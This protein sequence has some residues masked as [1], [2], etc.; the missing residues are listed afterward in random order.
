MLR[1]EVMKEKITLTQYHDWWFDNALEF[2]GSL[3]EELKITVD[4]DE[5]IAFN[6]L[7]AEQIEQ[8]VDKIEGRIKSKLTYPRINDAGVTEIK[9]RPYLPTMHKGKYVNFLGKDK[10]IKQEICDYLFSS[11]N[12]EGNKICDVCSSAYEDRYDISQ[13]S[14]IIYPAVTGSLKSQCGIRKME[15]EYHACP[16]CA[17]LGSIEWL[18]DNPF[19]CDNENLTNYILFPKIVDISDLHK[20][21]S[22][23]RGS[24]T[25]GNLTN[26]IHGYYTSK[27]GMQY[28]RYAKDQFSLLLSL[29]ELLRKNIKR[30]NRAEDLLCDEWVSVKIGGTD[31]TYQTR[32]TYLEE[33]KIPNIE[34]L[35]RLLSA[36]SPYANIVDKSFTKYISDKGINNNLSQEN[37]YFL[38]KG[39]I[40]DDFSTFAKAFQVRHNCIITGISKDLLNRLV[41][42]WKCKNGSI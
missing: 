5:G 39:L 26:L 40:M 20:F 37:K 42:L 12:T 10:K 23:M 6:K 15:P 32:Y 3:L 17:F 36:I 31:A 11:L 28:E 33:I 30:I 34:T 22:I 29:Y 8:L 1:A 18:D 35:E 14:Q 38:S 27:R 16:R 25:Q 21:K 4:W 7:D 2:L 41:Y 19:A 13:V 24:L 9:N